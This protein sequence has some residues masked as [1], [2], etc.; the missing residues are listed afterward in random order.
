MSVCNRAYMEQ[1][2]PAIDGRDAKEMASTESALRQRNPRVS[3]ELIHG[4]VQHVYANLMPAKVHTYLP[5][6]ISRQVQSRLNA[7]PAD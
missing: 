3:P 4:L 2:Q 1:P 5:I 6:L 7:R